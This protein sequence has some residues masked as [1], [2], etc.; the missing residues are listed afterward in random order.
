MKKIGIAKVQVFVNIKHRQTDCS[1]I[2]H[3][4]QCYLLDKTTNLGR[5][6]VTKI[7]NWTT[8][9]KFRL[10][11]F[12]NLAE[13]DI[14]TA[15]HLACFARDVW[16]QCVRL[17][18]GFLQVKATNDLYSFK[19]TSPW[20]CCSSLFKNRV[21]GTFGFCMFLPVFYL[22]MAPFLASIAPTHHLQAA[23]PFDCLESEKPVR[24]LDCF[25]ETRAPGQIAVHGQKQVQT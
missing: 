13:F 11:Q 12:L 20:P 1:R 7:R 25:S 4:F 19:P 3:G 5:S 10:G 2:S 23:A 17:K 9:T 16:W 18:H 15:S 21:R 14:E 6:T 8:T 22:R 24:S